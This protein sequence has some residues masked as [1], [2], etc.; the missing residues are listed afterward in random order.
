MQIACIVNKERHI[1]CTFYEKK[2][3]HVQVIEIGFR[4]SD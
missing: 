1:Y 3:K 2:K 4:K